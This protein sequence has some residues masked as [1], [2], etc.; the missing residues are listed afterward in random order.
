MT[1]KSLF[2]YVVVKR[3]YST[4]SVKFKFEHKWNVLK[5]ILLG[6]CHERVSNSLFVEQEDVVMF[7]CRNLPVTLI[8][9]HSFKAPGLRLY[10]CLYRQFECL[11]LCFISSLFSH[12]KR[13]L[14]IILSSIIRSLIHYTRVRAYQR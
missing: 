10:R 8:W 2:K 13:S 9:N 12:F 6:H 4:V 14:S 5:N 1:K 3:S 11:C 7:W